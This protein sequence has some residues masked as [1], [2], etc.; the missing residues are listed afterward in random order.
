[1]TKVLKKDILGSVELVITC[2]WNTEL[3]ELHTHGT[4]P[5]IWNIW[6]W[7]WEAAS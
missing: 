5:D 7:T 1:M 4:Y 2:I 3:V 6:G